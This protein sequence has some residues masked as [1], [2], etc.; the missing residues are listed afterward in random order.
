MH[1]G[2]QDLFFT[3]C[4][5]VCDLLPARG[6]ERDRM[7]GTSLGFGVSENVEKT[8]VIAARCSIK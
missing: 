1:Y 8:V 7:S 6:N 2:I 5:S 4:F 3:K